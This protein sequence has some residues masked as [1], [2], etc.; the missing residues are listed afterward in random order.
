VELISQFTIADLAILVSLAGGV[1][2]GFQQGLLRYILNCVVVL[3]A[4]IVASLLRDPIADALGSVWTMGTPDQQALWIYLVLLAAGIIGGFIVVRLFYRQ[5]RLPIIR[6][7]DEVGGAV[8]GVLWVAL[9]YTLS[10]VALDTFF[11]STD[12]PSV[13]TMLGPIYDIMNESFI[14]SWFREWLL[15]IVGFVL[16]PFVPDDIAPFLT[17]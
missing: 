9:I 7:L 10:W 13:A 6:Q 16:R 12:D 17:S 14:L 2:V 11:L 8:V 15:P 5:T 1:L 4:F 3:V